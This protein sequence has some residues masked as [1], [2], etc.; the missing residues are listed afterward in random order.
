[1]SSAFPMD[2]LHPSQDQESGSPTSNRDVSLPRHCETKRKRRRHQT[3]EFTEF[4]SSLQASSTAT[5]AAVLFALSAAVGVHGGHISGSSIQH[6]SQDDHGNYAFSY[7]IADP[8]GSSNGRWEIGDAFGN[9]RGGYT[10]TE[11]DG[12]KR[13]VE[14]V[15]D[16]HGFR[17]VVRTNEPGTAASATGAAVIASP[18]TDTGS[19]H[20]HR[21]A[22]NRR[23]QLTQHEIDYAPLI[24]TESAAPHLET[25][26]PL[27]IQPTAAKAPL[28]LPKV[29]PVISAHPPIVVSPRN[30]GGLG[31]AASEVGNNL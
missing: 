8:W 26:E 29:A 27:R 25:F 30:Y 28:R 4:L 10:I 7:N 11:A 3:T 16:K 17:V 9:K 13:Y 2:T 24:A 19:V 20:T 12:R 23:R 31:A 6:R 14:Y 21:F 5:A 15:A 22:P 1:M 18:Y